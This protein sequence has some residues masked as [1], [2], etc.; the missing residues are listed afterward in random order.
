MNKNIKLFS[1][2]AILSCLSAVSCSGG[3]EQKS[4]YVPEVIN[5]TQINSV[6]HEG[7]RLEPGQELTISIN[8]IAK[9]YNYVKLE[10][11]SEVNLVGHYQYSR[12]T[13]SEEP[14]ENVPVKESIF[15][16]ACK[17]KT[18][19]CHFF[20]AYRPETHDH[21]S[22]SAKKAHDRY[23]I[24]TV[25]QMAR[26][27]FDK[28]LESIT[29]K[30]VS[31]KA[32]SFVVYG[33]YLS[34]RK[35]PMEEV[36]L[37]KDNIK[38][39]VD[40]MGGG[41]LTYLERTCYQTSK[42]TY[43]IDEVVTNDDK[44]YIGVDASK[45][46]SMGGKEGSNDHHVNLVNYYDAGRQIQQSFYSDVGGSKKETKGENG[47]TR[48]FCTTADD[49]GYYW[50]YNP[51]QGG[52]C[53]CNI[54]QIVDFKRTENSLYVRCK[55]LDWAGNNA[56]TDS[57]MENLYVINNGMVYVTNRFTNF[58]GFTGMETLNAHVLELP[59]TYIAHPLN[60]LVTYQGESPWTNDK[61][62]LVYQSDLKSWKSGAD[63]IYKHPED[64]FAWVNDDRFGVGMYIPEMTI[65]AS[66]RSVTST[67]I[68]EAGNS[69]A[70][71]SP[72]G[73]KDKLAYNKKEAYYNFQSC[74]TTNTDYTAPEINT[75]M[76]DYLPFQYQYVLSVDYLDVIRNNFKNVYKSKVID[77]TT[78]KV[79][80]EYI[81]K[82]K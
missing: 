14:S 1:L 44:V 80:D 20:D 7:Y 63:V 59:A 30:N 55:P 37:E 24:P 62:G 22:C 61:T 34:D 15:I 81:A 40:L 42:Q 82:H 17:D 13:P 78:I 19:F 70:F 47:Y 65:F 36:Y 50:P 77:N 69:N 18:E 43:Y 11:K 72:M 76:I 35:L 58:A 26:G 57:Y 2:I 9:N 10:M 25:T 66:G 53:H 6:K 33:L 60:T 39:G 45:F 49:D 79:W 3:N 41:T 5:F 51:V 74:Y 56:V 54:S 46:V 4:E 27:A 52:D 38:I 21:S 16:E 32:G 68:Q 31:D 12:L 23:N 71:N 48:Y 28:Q 67:S 8:C 75:V 64:W 73:N 29:L